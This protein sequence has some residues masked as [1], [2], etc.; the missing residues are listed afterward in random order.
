MGFAREVG[1]RVLFMADGKIVEQNTPAEIFNHP[2]EERTRS[3][4]AKVL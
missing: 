2:Q 4:L 1:D 3:F